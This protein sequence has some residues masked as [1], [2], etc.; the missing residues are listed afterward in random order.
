MAQQQRP[1][2]NSSLQNRNQMQSLLTSP[3]AYASQTSSNLAQISRNSSQ[4]PPPL[5]G[6]NQTQSAAAHM[7]QM[8]AAAMSSYS[9]QQHRNLNSMTNGRSITSN[10]MLAQ[11]ASSTTQGNK[12]D[13]RVIP[14]P[15]QGQ[16]NNQT[17]TSFQSYPAYKVQKIVIQSVTVSCIN[18]TA[19]VHQDPLMLLPDLKDIFFPTLQSLDMCRKLLATLDI[20]LYKG[21]R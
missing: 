6:T 17:A 20:Q 3:Y 10:S 13:Y 12:N 21:N 5:V 9:P 11:R 1:T 2:Y 15:S 7:S 19:Y 8:A 16:D 4:A 14:Y 18:M